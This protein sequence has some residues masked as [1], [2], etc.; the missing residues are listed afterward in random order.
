[1]FGRKTRQRDAVTAALDTQIRVLSDE[2]NKGKVTCDRL[3][4]ENLTYVA[5]LDE[6][7]KERDA[8]RKECH[9]VV[10]VNRDQAARIEALE[11]QVDRCDGARRGAIKD[12]DEA[13][14]KRDEAL[15]KRDAVLRKLNEQ[16]LCEICPEMG[17]LYRESET[18]KREA[19]DAHRQIEALQ[20]RLQTSGQIVERKVWRV[21]ERKVWRVRAK[22]LELATLAQA[23]GNGLPEH[24]EF[25]RAARKLGVPV[26]EV[27]DYKLNQDSLEFYDWRLDCPQCSDERYNTTVYEVG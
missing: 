19:E 21:V 10:K 18:R 9:E 13:L 5:R 16:P 24:V 17:R 3:I 27:K 11:E 1:M 15:E 20:E 7:I 25:W 14:K 22:A 23:T 4:R 8:A 12:R 26:D 6:A 2:Y